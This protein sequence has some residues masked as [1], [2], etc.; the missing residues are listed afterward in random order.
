MFKALQWKQSPA[1]DVSTWILNILWHHFNGLKVSW[2]P[3]IDD[4]FKKY[5]FVIFR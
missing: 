1:A 3:K 5:A 4:V 2:Y